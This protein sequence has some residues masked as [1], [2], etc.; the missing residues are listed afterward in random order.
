[1]SEDNNIEKDIDQIMTIDEKTMELFR[2]GETSGVPYFEKSHTQTL[3]QFGVV[4]VSV[5]CTAK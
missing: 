3:L 4:P 2:K 5:S 1:M